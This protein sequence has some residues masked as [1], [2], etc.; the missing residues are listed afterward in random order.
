M[1]P[2]R[3]KSKLSSTEEIQHMDKKQTSAKKAPGPEYFTDY[4]YQTSKKIDRPNIIYTLTEHIK[5]EVF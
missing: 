1:I 4:F 2:D 3:K 5:R